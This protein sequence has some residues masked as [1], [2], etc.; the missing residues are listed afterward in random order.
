LKTEQSGPVTKVWFDDVT[1]GWEQWLLLRSDAHHDSAHC[2]RT[3]EYKHLDEA[4]RRHALIL[5]CGD[6]FDAMQGR[7]DPRRSYE[8]L[9]R[10]YMTDR[11]YDA[12]LEDTAVHY[13]PYAA[14]WLLLGRGNH[15]SAVTRNVNID[16]T[17][18]L[19][20]ELNR[21]GGSV[22]CGGY[23]GYVI[24][25]FSDG[26]S[27][28][29][30]LKIKYY[31]GSGDGAPV[32]KGVIQTARQAVYLPDADV[33]W[34]G[35]NHNEYTLSLKRERI[36]TK[37]QLYFDVC[38]FIRTPGYKNDYKQG[39]DGWAVEQGHPPR[40]LGACWLRL[41]SEGGRVK[42]QPIADVE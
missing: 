7:Y 32:T 34:N 11:Y 18:R 8:D 13:A 14:N 30:S 42:A 17:S 9:R 33:V 25:Y 41:Y 10:E 29:S 1:A 31:H 28:R 22:V 12:I 2:N 37:G 21:A 39:V 19:A 20:A 15:E 38:H 26:G 36:T 40:P 24:L 5:D 4:K 35:H 6:L 27:S 3:L 16:L 23:G